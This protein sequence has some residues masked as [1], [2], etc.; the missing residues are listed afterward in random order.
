MPGPRRAVADEVLRA[1]VER[2]H[3][4]GRASLRALADKLGLSPAGV[5][6][7]I[8]GTKLRAETRRALLDWYTTE[9][10]L[11]D[12][13]V[14]AVSELYVA[15]MLPALPEAARLKVARAYAREAE[16]EYQRL[17]IAPPSWIREL[18]GEGG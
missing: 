17:R 15:R 4:E 2:A 10:P 14:W 6:K 1:A 12:E 9:P 13:P 3:R 8:K 16:A 7:I 18:R 5:L 11:E